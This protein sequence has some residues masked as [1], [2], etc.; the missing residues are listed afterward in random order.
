MSKRMSIC[1][2]KS[3]SAFFVFRQCK[4]RNYIN[5]LLEYSVSQ[6]TFIRTTEKKRNF[7]Q[8]MKIPLKILGRFFRHSKG[9]SLLMT[10]F[11]IERRSM[12]LSPLLFL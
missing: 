6:S 8:S 4:G 11:N 3:R 5:A 1:I 7:H 2:N 10:D 9:V 12:I